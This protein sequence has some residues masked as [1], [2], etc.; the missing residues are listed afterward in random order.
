MVDVV[1]ELRFD[2]SPAQNPAGTYNH[3]RH[4]SPFEKLIPMNRRYGRVADL[5][6]E[7]LVLLAKLR[8]QRMQ[9]HLVWFANL[10]MKR[11]QLDSVVDSVGLG[12]TKKVEASIVKL[13]IAHG[14]VEESIDIEGTGPAIDIAAY[15]FILHE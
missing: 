2:I 6:H 4:P 8:S 15:V 7:F 1:K 11:T 13:T 9:C 10:R 5:A 12:V 3:D 14:H